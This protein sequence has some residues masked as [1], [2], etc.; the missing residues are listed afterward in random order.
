V[1][2]PSL[3]EEQ[4]IHEAAE[5]THLVESLTGAFVESPSGYLP[6]LETYDTGPGSYLQLIESAKSG[7]E[8]PVIASLNGS[9]RGGW[10]RYARLIE[11]AG[12]DALELNI[13]VVAADPS[14]DAKAIEDEYLELVRSVSRQ[15]DIP[16]AVKVSPYFSA[17]ANM[18]GRLIEA[19]ADALVLFNRFYQPDVDL[20]EMTVTP[21]LELSTSHDL[22]LPLRWIAILYGQ[23]DAQLA[24]TSG[25][26]SEVDVVKLLLAG[27]DVTMTTASLLRHGP[28]HLTEIVAN[29]ERW[30]DDNDYTSV[31]QLR[32][33]LSQGNAPDPMAFERHN[34]MKALTTFGATPAS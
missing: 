3:F 18:A 23:I 20:D 12:A 1:V 14:Y 8:I 5:V 27:A 22:R 21:N 25:V 15:I 24:A 28:T 34:Y 6:D 17:F 33:S 7:L 19:G 32:G 11:D 31:A 9:T 10:T 26:H 29:L 2:L 13:Y 4:I 16:L 30:L